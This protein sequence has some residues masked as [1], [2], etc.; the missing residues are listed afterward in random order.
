M[1]EYPNNYK[2]EIRAAYYFRTEH[3]ARMVF[4]PD[5]DIERNGMRHVAKGVRYC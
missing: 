1:D 4:R 3:S 2:V 5:D